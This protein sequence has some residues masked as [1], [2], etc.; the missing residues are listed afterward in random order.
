MCCGN[1]HG[2]HFWLRVIFIPIV[3]VAGIFVLGSALMLLWNALMPSLFGI[4][5]IG[6]WQAI[7]I[8]ILAK[9]L[10]GGFHGR[11]CHCRSHGHAWKFREKWRNLTPEER[12][13]MKSEW[14]HRFGH[15]EKE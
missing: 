6:F 3:V 1:R 8:F 14:C 10:F 7:G 9:I 11:H 4:P 12:E 15:S 13:K 2:K 5:T